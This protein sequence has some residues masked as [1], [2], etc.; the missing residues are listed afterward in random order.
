ML[1]CRSIDFA[2]PQNRAGKFGF[3]G[4]IGIVLRLQTK[5][6]MLL[7][8]AA[9]RAAIE[10]VPPVKLPARLGLM[11]LHHAAAGWLFHARRQFEHSLLAAE[12]ET[13]L[14]ALCFVWV[15]F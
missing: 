7:E 10:K 4:R 1:R 5:A 14:V 15:F 9:P 6:F 11:N 13:V 8:S 3:I 2:G 12:R